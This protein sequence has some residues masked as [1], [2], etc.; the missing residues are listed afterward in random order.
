MPMNFKKRRT[1]LKAGALGLSSCLLPQTKLIAS[2]I[3]DTLSLAQKDLYGDLAE[4][5]KFDELNARAYLSLILTHT[6]IDDDTKEFIT[7]G[8]KWLDEEAVLLYKKPYISLETTKRQKV[9]ES[10]SKQEWGD[11][12]IYEMLSF[13]YEALLGDSIYAINKNG[14][15]W[16]WL[17]HASGTPRP[18]EALL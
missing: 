6:R 2:P 8:A 16:K 10:S 14:S 13:V 3:L 17:N 12:W 15:G 9:L 1:F 7:N 4:A 11:A 18:K 5:P